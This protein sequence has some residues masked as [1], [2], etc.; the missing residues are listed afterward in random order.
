MRNTLTLNLAWGD[1][2]KLYSAL[3]IIQNSPVGNHA[4]GTPSY[5]NYQNYTDSKQW[6]DQHALP[7]TAGHES[8]F[9]RT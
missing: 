2:N 4:K 5:F 1:S 7:F 6:H 8:P 9:T 3:A